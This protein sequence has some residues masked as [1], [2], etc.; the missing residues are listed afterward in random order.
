LSAQIY[1]GNIVI[2]Y[3]AQGNVNT[4]LVIGNGTANNELQI[5]AGT[6]RPTTI[7]TNQAQNMDNATLVAKINAHPDKPNDIN[8]SVSG[9]FVVITKSPTSSS[10]T[11]SSLTLSNSVATTLF[12]TG[13]QNQTMTG[14]QVAINPQTVQ[15]ARDSI[16]AA[17]ISGVTA[18]VDSNNRLVITSTNNT[19]DLGASN[20][21]NSRAGLPTGVQQTQA[22]VVANTFTAS[23][24]TDISDS[25]PALFKIQVIQDD[26]P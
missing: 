3:D 21:M 5:V 1:N 9:G 10:S 13:Q 7:Q 6:Y 2:I 18:S 4:N 8:A 15:N 20:N 25:D 17:N 26:N 16:N 23:D 19:L 14:S 11:T 22:T 24:W 12:P